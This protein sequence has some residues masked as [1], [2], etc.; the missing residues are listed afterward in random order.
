MRRRVPLW[1]TALV[2]VI[3]VVQFFVPHRP[4]SG[5]QGLLTDWGQVIVAFAIWLGA[6]NL[7]KVSADSVHRREKGWP[8]ATII[9][10]CFVA[11]VAVGLLFSGGPRFQD[12][13]T[14]FDWI[15]Q[16]VYNPLSAT[17]FAML[18]FYV[19]SASFRAFRARNR[20]ATLL[21]LAAFLV[22]L[23]RVP[24]GD[25]LTAFLPEGY[26]LS[27]LADWVMN[28]PNKAGQRAIMIGIALGIVSTSL[29]LILGIER[30]HLG[31]EG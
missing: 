14:P 10:A 1:I 12:P 22:M 21:L 24:V 16:N 4:F 2:G 11:T 31:G 29:R 19:A 9:I 5:L 6:L 27:N 20:E 7:M 17:M 23:G 25:S 28:V 30:S 18:A 15:Y 8:Y 26:R 3:F 13:G